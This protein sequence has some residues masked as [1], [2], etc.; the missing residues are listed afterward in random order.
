MAPVPP[1]KVVEF[2]RRRID[3]VWALELLLL[4][5]R[6]PVRAWSKGELVFELRAS[7]AVV[8]QVL[9]RFER[10]GLVERQKGDRFHFAGGATGLDRICDALAAAYRER[11]F[12][13]ISAIN[14]PEDRLA[15]L[16]D[17]F[18]LKKPPR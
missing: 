4:I 16:A 8:A 15:A 17:A 7:E 14:A 13:V 12:A 1:I 6:P 5:Q 10:G 11:P 9:S 18:R 2:V 3:S